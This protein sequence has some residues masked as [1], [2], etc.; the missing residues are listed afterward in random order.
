MGQ[1]EFPGS[2][3]AARPGEGA[4]SDAEEFS[5]HQSFWNGRHV[6]RDE[7]LVPPWTP[8]MDGLRQQLL[9]RARLSMEEHRRQQRGRSTGQPLHLHGRGAVS[10]E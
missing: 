1:L 5:L 6:D 7:G 4:W 2:V 3:L 9:A 10:D 8:R